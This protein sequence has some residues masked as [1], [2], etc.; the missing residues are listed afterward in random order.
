MGLLIAWLATLW[1]L[2][3]PINASPLE[4][5]AER[6]L[7]RAASGVQWGPCSIDF[8]QLKTTNASI[9]CG[10]VTVPLDYADSSKGTIQLNL[11][12]VHAFKGPAKGS[13]LLNYGGPGQPGRKLLVETIERAS[14]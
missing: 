13:V 10:N 2:R 1:L 8:Q 6:R 11:L 5:G 7:E 12:R 4:T 9:D 3:Q 14:M